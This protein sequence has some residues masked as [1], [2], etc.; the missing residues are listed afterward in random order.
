MRTKLL[1][2]DDEAGIRK[3]F[4]NVAER[5]GYEVTAVE[6]VDQFLASYRTQRPSVVVMDLMMPRKDGVE[7]MKS[8]ADDDCDLPIVLI[9]GSD[10]DL[11]GRVQRL[12]LA[13]G[14]DIRGVLTKPIMLDDL[15]ATLKNVA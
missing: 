14:L 6:T 10:G 12:G 2:V 7:L 1:L 15:E 8:L 3:L 4:T 11:L 5:M 9:S 13:R